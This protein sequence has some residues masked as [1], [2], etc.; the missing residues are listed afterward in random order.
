MGVDISARGCALRKCGRLARRLLLLTAC[1]GAGLALPSQGWAVPASLAPPPPAPDQLPQPDDSDAIVAP[2]AQV[3]TGEFKGNLLMI[4]AG[5]SPSTMPMATGTTLS[6]LPALTTASNAAIAATGGI[7]VQPTAATQLDGDPAGGW[8]V[9][10]DLRSGIYLDSSANPDA[11][12]SFAEFN[13]GIGYHITEDLEVGLALGAEHVAEKISGTASRTRRDG[14]LLGPYAV[15]SL[16]GDLTFEARSQWG[17]H[18]DDRREDVA[19]SLFTGDALMKRLLVESRLSSRHELGSLTISPDAAFFYGR[20]RHGGF[21]LSDGVSDL[22]VMP[23]T[24]TLARLSA[25]LALARDVDVAQ[26]TLTTHVA[27]RLSWDMIQ[28]DRNA[29]QLRATLSAGLAYDTG[30][31]TLS[32]SAEWDGIASHGHESA[33]ARVSFTREF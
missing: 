20:D 4:R 23:D 32:A 8:S 33:A 30:A 21:T 18:D 1:L 15:I 22:D 5:S 13:I 26:A 17:W 19:G 12:G 10:S 6:L 28:P 3:A 2:P 31:G 11:T 7:T 29:D 14:V 24:E 16:P 9:W 27:A 25:G